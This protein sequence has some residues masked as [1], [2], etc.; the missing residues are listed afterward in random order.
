V[1]W[2]KRKTD[3][4]ILTSI[5]TDV[6][7]YILVLRSSKPCN[8][9][10]DL[11]DPDN[12][13][14]ESYKSHYKFN[15]FKL[16]LHDI[17]TLLEDIKKLADDGH[18]FLVC[19]AATEFAIQN[20]DKQLRRLSV[21]R[22]DQPATLAPRYASIVLL[23]IDTLILPDLTY[24]AAGAQRVVNHLVE[25][26][27]MPELY[28]T[29]IIY[30]WTSKAGMKPAHV[31]LRLI[32]LLSEL[33]HIDVIKAWA[34][35]GGLVDTKIYD[36]QQPIYIANP[37]F[38][39]GS[40]PIKPED[41]IGLL[42]GEFD[43]LSPLPSA[44]ISNPINA[45]Q[46][47]EQDDIILATLY[48]QGFIK[49]KLNPGKY[50][51]TCPWVHE[52]TGEVDS[53]TV[54]MLPNYS[55]FSQ[56]A[57]KCQ[58]EHCADKKLSDLLAALQINPD[59]T[60]IP[61][62]DDELDDGSIKALVQRYAYMKDQDRFFDF[63]TG[64]VLK[65]ESINRGYSHIHMR[66]QAGTALLRRPDLIRT[67]S[68]VY[69]PGHPRVTTWNNMRVIN[70]WKQSTT[71]TPREGDPTPWLKHVKWLIK[72]KA[73]RIHILDWCAY[74]VQHMDIKIN[75]AILLGGPP[76]I[77]K[78]T[79]LEPLK[80]YLGHYN[81]N[82]PSAEE[83]KE[84]YTNYLHH[85][86]LV[87]FQECQNFDKL[88][89]ENKLKPML[90]SPPHTLRVR[91]FAQGFYETPNLVQ[92][93][94]MSNHRNALKISRGDGRYYTIWCEVTPKADSYYQTL[95][96]WLEGDYGYEIVVNFLLN[97]NVSHFNPTA[98]PPVNEY[99]KLIT[100]MSGTDLE[101]MLQERIENNEPPFHRDIV[102]VSDIISV[103]GWE[104]VTA[105]RFA[106]ALDSLGAIPKKVRGTDEK[107]R[108]HNLWAI[109]H[110]K[111]WLEASSKK[112]LD[113]F[114]KGG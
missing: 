105:K 89:V 68:M 23:D 64:Q 96:N 37:T 78:D 59:D 15:F 100:E 71:L 102:K 99:K 83:L 92:C 19:G 66:P 73:D 11:A 72:A 98:P 86:K 29:K 47:A 111:K 84:P 97:R 21:S 22:E 32:V 34:T 53:G 103:G 30:Q 18:Y 12:W 10:I 52:H 87:I 104:G 39:N 112:W 106:T 16:P 74:M 33:T 109:H 80:R 40:P 4:E 45:P 7:D 70:M 107:R 8:K 5:A 75:H 88:N 6:E 65:I 69:L 27:H 50:D 79:L 110:H 61:L 62:E 48:E 114:Q 55:G 2:K 51:I 26:G 90:A 82:E 24:D 42:D 44:P 14:V 38:V 58:H 28:N 54:F 94:F 60:T 63:I 25:E 3:T 81:V 57:F 93:V 1:A 108:T 17:D 20:A 56:H 76:R 36:P 13:V 9:Q 77:G 91:M 49:T 41:R 46:Q 85:T 101:I 113:Y 35:V 43:E 31:R 67:D 95:Y